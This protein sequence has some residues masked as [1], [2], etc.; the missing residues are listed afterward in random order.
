MELKDV[1][2]TRRS[3]RKFS[4]EKISHETIT[5]LLT[6]AMSAPSACNKRP[7]EFY[8]I[9]DPELLV[10]LKGASP[11]SK[12]NAPLAIVVAADKKKCLK[13]RMADYWVQDCSAATENLL[14]RAVDL[15]LGSVWCGIHLQPLAVKN[16]KEILQ[17]EED[18]MPLNLIY[19]GV[20][21]ETPNAR[22][23]FDPERVHYIK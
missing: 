2:L 19:L 3:V 20:P 6:A 7:W 12:I 1:I 22:G 15:G 10:K 14:L 5:E 16:L 9:E 21:M 8:V 11:F 4:E 13:S 23:G 17:L 18:I